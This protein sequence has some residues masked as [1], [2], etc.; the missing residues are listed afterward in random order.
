MSI[1]RVGSPAIPVKITEYGTRLAKLHHIWR[2]ARTYAEINSYKVIETYGV[3][4]VAPFQKSAV[5]A[6]LGYLQIPHKTPI[7]FYEIFDNKFSEVAEWGS[8]E[9][10]K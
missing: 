2:A 1:I 3:M 5:S 6:W 7:H 10:T 4:G 9:T 8:G